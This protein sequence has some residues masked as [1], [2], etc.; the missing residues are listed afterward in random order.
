MEKKKILLALL[1]HQVEKIKS[2]LE[3]LGYKMFVSTEPDCYAIRGEITR[4][5][6]GDSPI[7]IIFMS[8]DLTDGQKKG[9]GVNFLKSLRNRHNIETPTVVV[10]DVE[11]DLLGNLEVVH[12][13]FAAWLPPPFSQA[14]VEAV[15]R[16]VHKPKI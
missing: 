8:S 16:H 4:A 10:S 11:P 15:L 9:Q 6:E 7:D 14:W 5:M 2:A 3:T 13:H 1:P 12:Q